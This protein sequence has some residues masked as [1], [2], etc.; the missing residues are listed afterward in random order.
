MQLEAEVKI[1]EH[2]F[3]IN[4]GCACRT[5]V[6]SNDNSTSQGMLAGVLTN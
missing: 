2:I 4:E 1:Q 5:A 3:I 6:G